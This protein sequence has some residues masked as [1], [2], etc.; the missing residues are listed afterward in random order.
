M[1]RFIKT[2]ESELK[3]IVS[4]K[5]GKKSSLSCKK[6][7]FSSPKKAQAKID[8]IATQEALNG[9]RPTR[10]YMC[11]KCGAYHLTSMSDSFF[12]ELIEK[13]SKAK[14][15]RLFWIANYW[16]EKLQVA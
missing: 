5:Y 8:Q 11:S 13:K 7:C 14:M 9:T 15:R 2:S 1:L 6:S 3:K 10:Y 4:S 16:E 12:S